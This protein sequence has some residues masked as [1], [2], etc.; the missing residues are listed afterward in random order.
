MNKTP[1]ELSRL[2]AET[3]SFDR[4]PPPFYIPDYFHAVVRGEV[5]DVEQEHK[6]GHNAAV[7]SSFETIWSEGDLYVYRTTET[8]LKISSGNVND[9]SAGSGAQT[10]QIDGLDG[11]YNPISEVVILNGRTEVLTIHKYL[12]VHRMMVLTA[13]ATGWN[14][15]TVYSGTG[16]VTTGVPAVVHGAIEISMN[17]TL[18]GFYTIRN[19]YTGYL[20]TYEMNSSVTQKI[21]ARLMVRELGSVFQVKDLLTF[22]SDHAVS[23]RLFPLKILE[24]SD[25]EVQALTGAGGGELGSSFTISMERN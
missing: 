25:I 21:Q 12:R 19:G 4:Q 2:L 7:G 8:V 14:E 17:Q 16:T 6:F 22:A 23:P 11:A 1:M 15:G 13:G 18:M 24:K 5:P 9:T 3:K 10:I 20:H